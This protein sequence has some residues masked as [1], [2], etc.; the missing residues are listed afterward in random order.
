MNIEYNKLFNSIDNN[1]QIEISIIDKIAWFNII[2]LNYE[3]YKTFLILLKDI[4]LYL[5]NKKIEYIK[6]YIKK[7][8]LEY[9]SKSSFNEYGDIYIISTKLIDFTDEISNVLGIKKI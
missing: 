4:I 6:Q 2:K 7:E 5:S 9:F 1:H 3:Q 8:D